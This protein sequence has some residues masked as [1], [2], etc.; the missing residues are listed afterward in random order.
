M[1]MQNLSLTER[2]FTLLVDALDHLP[3]KNIASDLMGDLLM[4]LST[5]D[6][7]QRK[8]ILQDRA[9]KEVKLKKDRDALMEDVRILQGKLLMFKR[10][11]IENN[12]LQQV[13]EIL[14]R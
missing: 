4:G 2:D 7:N 3:D 6:E 8:K 13:D 5:Q 1:E 11:L 14:S 10:Y 9:L 12:A